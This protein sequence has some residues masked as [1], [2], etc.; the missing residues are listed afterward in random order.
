MQLDAKVISVLDRKG[1][2]LLSV[3]PQVTVFE[4][5]KEM[6]DRD[7]GALAVLEGDLLVGVFS[8]R[9][10][11]RKVIL[12][13]KTSRETR[14]DEVMS[15]PA[16]T[17]PSLDTVDDALRM[18]TSFRLRH[19]VVVEGDRPI[20]MVSIGDLVNWIISAQVEMIGHLQSYI[21]G[22]YPA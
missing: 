5:L 20:G 11:A 14:V 17:V 7:V 15:R 13:G 22:T 2:G 16:L 8:E 6:A 18:M 10:Y 1:R 3:G 21:S 19:L 4:A 12:L 9:D